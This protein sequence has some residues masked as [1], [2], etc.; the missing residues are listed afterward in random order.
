MLDR[1]VYPMVKAI[2]EKHGVSVGL[3]SDFLDVAF[4]VSKIGS[5][6]NSELSIE[7][8]GKHDIFMARLGRIEE[9]ARRYD[10]LIEAEKKSREEM[11]G[12]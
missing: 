1:V 5:K 8:F 3:M 7:D 2:A 11:D 6:S 9:K 4:I 10:L 12:K